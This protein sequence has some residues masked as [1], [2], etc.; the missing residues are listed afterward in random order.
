MLQEL[1]MVDGV[2]SSKECA[3][4]NLQLDKVYRWVASN[5]QE[6]LMFLAILWKLSS[7]YLLKQ[8]PV[9]VNLPPGIIDDSIK[10][11]SAQNIDNEG[12]FIGFFCQ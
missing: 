11:V 3:E 7:K 1:K 10:P 5:I 4:F 2:N 9:F 12:N 8:N 6:R